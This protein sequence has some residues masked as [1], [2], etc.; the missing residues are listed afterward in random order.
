MPDTC[1]A[2]SIHDQ[3]PLTY[4]DHCLPDI[5]PRIHFG[6]WWDGAPGDYGVRLAH[7]R[8]GGCYECIDDTQCGQGSKCDTGW[9]TNKCVTAECLRDDHCN[10]DQTCD[11][12]TKLCTPAAA[13]APA[14]CPGRR[15][16]RSAEAVVCSTEPAQECRAQGGYC[17]A[18]ASCPGTRASNEGS[19]R[20]HNHG[21][22]CVLCL[23]RRPRMGLLSA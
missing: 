16:R 21:E 5:S 17:G 19:R 20:L 2:P 14:A 6:Y 4:P 10:A 9:L 11:A 8:T 3:L 13:D 1:A 7:N 22:C 12:E 18:P 15:R 23:N